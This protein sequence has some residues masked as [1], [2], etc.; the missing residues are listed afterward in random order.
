MGRGAC[1]FLDEINMETI[2]KIVFALWI[3][4][5][6]VLAVGMMLAGIVSAFVEAWE[7]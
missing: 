4:A 2:I 1:L 5:G 7:K 3:G 6:V